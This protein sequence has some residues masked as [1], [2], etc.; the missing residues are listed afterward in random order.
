MGKFFTRLRSRRG[1]SIMEVVIT[2]AIIM[3]VSMAA[4]TISVSSTRVEANNL[5]ATTIIRQ[6]ESTVDCFRFAKSQSE[7]LTA[8]QLLDGEFAPAEAEAGTP[9]TTVVYV[10]EKQSYRLEITADFNANSLEFYAAK[11][12]GEEI[13]RLNYEKSYQVS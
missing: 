7:F 1:F 12:D 5:R 9:A 8:L 4:L 2:L 13:Y 3:I 11:P 6:Y 10:L